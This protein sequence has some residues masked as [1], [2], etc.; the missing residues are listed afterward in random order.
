MNFQGVIYFCFNF[1]SQTVGW[2]C[3][4][5]SDIEILYIFVLFWYIFETVEDEE[6]GGKTRWGWDWLGT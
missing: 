6:G 2:C 5:Y 3:F 4:L 1:C